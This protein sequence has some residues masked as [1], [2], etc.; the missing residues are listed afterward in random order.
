MRAE[1]PQRGETV[2]ERKGGKL[3]VERRIIRKREREKREGEKERE[4]T[5]KKNVAKKK[6]KNY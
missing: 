5:R 4:R 2:S 6:A 1:S 3:S